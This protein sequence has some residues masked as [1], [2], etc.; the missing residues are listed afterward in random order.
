MQFDFIKYRRIPYIFSA[1]LVGACL[2]LIAV[3]GLKWSIDFTG[4]SVLSLEYE[5]QAPS[6]QEI[7]RVI[8]DMGLSPVMV[9]KETDKKVILKLPYINEQTHQQIL[10]RLQ[11]TAKIQTGSEQFE[12]IGPVIG[13]ELK[14]KIKVV[15]VLSLLAI[16]VYII[17]AFGRV[18]FP[19][20]SSI[21]GLMGTIALFHDVTI[22][23]GVWALLG[24]YAGYEVSIPVI[25]ALLTVFGYS[26]NDTVVVFDRIRENLIKNRGEDF[27]VIVN[28]SLNDTLVRSVNTSLTV[29]IVLLFLFFLG[30]S[31]LKPFSLTLII[32][33]GLGTYSSIFLASPLVYSFYKIKNRKNNK[34]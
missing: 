13:K 16:L 25:T 15:I 7:Q 22:P 26:I 27:G 14:S 30:G 17:I 24:K 31:T 34:K 9:Q 18:S 23:L 3:F 29:L 21:Y 4:G 8:S 6:A 20:K 1:G 2:V 33:I 12:T 32:G 5:S 11:E 28:K 19:V 10:S